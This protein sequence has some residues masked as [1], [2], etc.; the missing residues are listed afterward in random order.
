MICRLDWTLKDVVEAYK[1]TRP[2]GDLLSSLEIAKIEKESPRF[3]YSYPVMDCL[4]GNITLESLDFRDGDRITFGIGV[5][6]DDE[7]TDAEDTE[8]QEEE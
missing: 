5:D 1:E 7:Q 3:P 8:E 2:V 4:N 6:Y